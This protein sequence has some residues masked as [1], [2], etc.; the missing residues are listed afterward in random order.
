MSSRQTG[1]R[2]NQ[3]S[4][5]PEPKSGGI[6]APS[7]LGSLLGD[8]LVNP[9]GVTVG[10]D[11]KPVYT[12]AVGKGRQSSINAALLNEG[13]GKQLM[14]QMHEKELSAQ[15]AKQAE[16]LQKQFGDI[17]KMLGES[18]V[19]NGIAAKLGIPP[20]ELAG[21]ITQELHNNALQKTR[22]EGAA[23]GSDEVKEATTQGMVAGL[24]TPAVDNASKLGMT[25]PSGSIAMR[26]AFN[27]VPG[28]ELSGATPRQTNQPDI[29]NYGKG[30]MVMGLKTTQDYSPATGRQLFPAGSNDLWDAAKNIQPPANG[31]GQSDD[32]QQPVSALKNYFDSGNNQPQ[33]NASLPGMGGLLNPEQLTNLSQ[34]VQSGDQSSII[35]FYSDLMNQ[36]GRANLNTAQP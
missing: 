8:K 3:R 26:P 22:N 27:G 28:L 19:V 12:P 31:E 23:L 34:A 18:A 13:Y 9:G 30:P 35:K 14:G 24:Q 29:R 2:Y 21:T 6:Q 20:S 1:S 5:V 25:A 33:M 17:Q 15:E 32:S 16:E 4:Y 36:M 10:P 11:G 7:L